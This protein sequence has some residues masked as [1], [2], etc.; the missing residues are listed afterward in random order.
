MPFS[1]G[2]LGA[3]AGVERD[4]QRD[5]SGALHRDPVQRQAVAR[6]EVVIVAM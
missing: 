6:T 2:P 4:H 3:G 1:S 5:G